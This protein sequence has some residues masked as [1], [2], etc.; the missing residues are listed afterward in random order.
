PPPSPSWSPPFPR[1]RADRSRW[2]A[3]AS[4]GSGD[5]PVAE[6]TDCRDPAGLLQRAPD[7]VRRLLDALPEARLVGAPNALQQ[8]V[9]PV[10][11][12][13]T[14]GDKLQHQQRASLEL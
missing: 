4:S 9:S 10:H 3:A 7:L 5:K 13:G 12:A 2:R 14:A 6:S 8:L 11:L 1:A